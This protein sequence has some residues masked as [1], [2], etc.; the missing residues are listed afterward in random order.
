MIGLLTKSEKK[1][2]PIVHGIHLPIL[3]LS[4]ILLPISFAPK[5]IQ[6]AAKLNPIYYVVEA[7]RSIV[8]GDLGSPKV[9]M[10]FLVVI[11]M[12]FISMFFATRVFKKAVM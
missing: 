6:I 12:C 7:A 2:A 9:L 5:E 3:L 8:I 10:G 1:V 11:P 4:G